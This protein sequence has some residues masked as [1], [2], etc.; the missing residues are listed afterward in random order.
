MGKNFLAEKIKEHINTRNI[1]FFLLTAVALIMAYSPVMALYS[2]DKS[3]Y[4]SHI[5]LIP[6]MSI[7]LIYIKRKEIFAKVD[8]L[9][10]VGIPVLLLGTTLFLGG[11]LWGAPLD[12]NNYASLINFSI[13]I[14]INGAFILLYGMRAYRSALF[15]LLFLIFT[16]PIPT[17]LM[18]NIIHFLQVGSTEFTNLLFL[19]SGVPFARDG[20]AFHL[21]NISVEVA[22]QCSGIRSG[23]AIF[24]VAILAGYMFLKSYWKIIFLVICAVLIALFKNGIR[25]FTLSLLGNYVDPRILSSSLHREGGIPF[26]IVALLLLAPILFFLRRS[27]KK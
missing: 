26:F 27:E 13:F 18:D 1:I 22:K 7:Y 5:A 6:L 4:Y 16:V 23:M 9:F 10:V 21:P 19:A 8:Y 24:I 25:I 3:E 15:P 20:F 14:F 11:L 17:A 2:S 12:K